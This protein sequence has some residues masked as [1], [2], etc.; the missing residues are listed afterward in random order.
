MKRSLV[1]GIL[2]LACAAIA[3]AF[4]HTFEL[5]SV[6]AKAVY[7]TY[8]RAKDWLVDTVSYGFKLFGGEDEGEAKP[9]VLLIQ[10][11]AF[12][13]RLAKRERPVLTSSWRMCPSC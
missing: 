1:F 5:P 10:A 8:K 7:R 4:T 2:A 11:K 3:S 12:V 9:A 6:F 13:M